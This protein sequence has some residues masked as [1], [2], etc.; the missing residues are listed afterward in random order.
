[1]AEPQ[2]FINYFNNKTF[3]EYLQSGEQKLFSRSKTG[4]RPMREGDIVVSVN[5]VTMAI[6]QI[7]IV[8]GVFRLRS[9]LDP[10]IYSGADAKYHTSEILLKH[11]PVRFETP[12]ALSDIAV[13]CG[14]PAKDGEANNLGSDKR[15]GG[16]KQSEYT[17]IFYKGPRGE[18]NLARFRAVVNGLIVRSACGGWATI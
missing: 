5:T 11:P 12:I 2:M 6:V 16:K 14:F 10:P 17:R 3:E 8:K 13:Q 9:L 1:M 15:G 18:E 4:S 7:S